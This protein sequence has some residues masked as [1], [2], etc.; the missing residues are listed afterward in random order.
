[1][2]GFA[3]V[4]PIVVAADHVAIRGEQGARAELDASRREYFAVEADIRALADHDVAVLAG[5]D[6][7]AADERACAD[8]DASIGVALRVDQALIVNHH[9]IADADL[10]RMPEDDVLSEDHAAAARSEEHRIQ[11]LAKREAERA[12]DPLRQQLDELVAE[13]RAPSVAADDQPRV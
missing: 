13:E 10:V 9:V 1:E 4:L 2:D 3:G 11:Q 6:G 12:G 7:I 5:Q 8:R